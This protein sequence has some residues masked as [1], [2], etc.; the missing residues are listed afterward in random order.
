MNI[1]EEMDELKTRLSTLYSLREY[2]K[3]A[4]STGSILPRH[5]FKELEKLDIE[6]SLLESQFKK[7]WDSS[8]Y[9]NES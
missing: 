1:I 4:L 2:L 6:L 3:S 7:L 5:G 8:N 9:L